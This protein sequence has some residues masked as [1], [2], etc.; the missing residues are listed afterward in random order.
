MNQSKDLP[1]FKHFQ[2]A[3]IEDAELPQRFID[4]VYSGMVVE[5][6]ANPD[7]FMRSIA[8]CLKPGGVHLFMTVNGS[9]YFGRM[10]RSLQRLGLEDVVPSGHQGASRQLPATTIPCN[11]A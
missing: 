4:L 5:H 7:A 2:H 11:T 8:R 6:V 1:I 3:T 10:S 9:H